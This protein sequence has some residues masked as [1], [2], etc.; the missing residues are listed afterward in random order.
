MLTGDFK[1]RLEKVSPF[2][3]VDTD[4]S[5]ENEHGQRMCGLY[6][7]NLHICSVPIPIVPETDVKTET[8]AIDSQGL[9]TILS[10]ITKKGCVSKASL[11]KEFGI[12]LGSLSID[13]S[14]MAVFRRNLYDLRRERG[15]L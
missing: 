1:K 7:T 6:F 8:G 9:R 15:L 11:E 14:S 10:I 4:K 13:Y 12:D 5:V 2:F 3:R